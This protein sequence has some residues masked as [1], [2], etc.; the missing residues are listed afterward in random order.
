[1]SPIILLGGLGGLGYAAYSHFRKPKASDFQ[2]QNVV[3][4]GGVP[5]KV[6]TPISSGVTR[7]QASGVVTA[8]PVTSSGSVLHVIKGQT[9]F[10]PPAAITQ[11]GPN[12]FQAP[13]IIMTPTGSSSVAIAGVA[14]VQRALNALGFAPRLA[15]DGKLGPKTSA[16][17]RAFQSKSGLVVDGN[18]GPATKAAL[19]TALTSMASSGPTAQ[20]VAKASSPGP[21]IG[22]AYASVNQTELGPYDT[23]P[24]R[25]G[26][27]TPVVN[28]A[29][30][31][32]HALNLLGTSPPLQED[33][34]IGPK[35]VA[36]IKSFQMTHGL[37]ADGVA[38]PK[39]KSA[40]AAAVGH[41][42]ASS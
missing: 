26:L 2:T 25:A 30:D 40:L 36:A 23:A 33:G 10:A 14:D 6:L 39:T 31:V 3:S 9:V 18:A 24:N 19:S 41:P 34:N 1:M 28:S 12:Q 35:S 32:Q 37:A 13:P 27:A 8:P 22:P 17:I 5:V 42:V 38:G 21:A 4:Q 11:T 29:R 15:E 20:V 7:S 16:N